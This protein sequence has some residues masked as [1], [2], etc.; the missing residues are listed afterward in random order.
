VV[1]QSPAKVGRI[2]PAS[3]NTVGGGA[4]H[5]W[6]QAY[7]PRAGRIDFDPTNQSDRGQAESNSRCGGVDARP[8]LAAI[9]HPQ[10]TLQAFQDTE[11]TLELS[12]SP[13]IC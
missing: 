13:A 5:A 9:G 12:E 3:S 11:V 8:S 6:M 10:G 4:T 2:A 7:L 1:G